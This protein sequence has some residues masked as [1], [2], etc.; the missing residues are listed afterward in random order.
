MTTR[1]MHIGTRQQLAKITNI[2]IRIGQVSVIPSDC[3]HNLGYFMDKLLKKA[4]HINTILA[5]CIELYR[6]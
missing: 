1:Q 2:N 3:V 4:G 6:T 5:H